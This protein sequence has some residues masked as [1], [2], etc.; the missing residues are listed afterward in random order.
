MALARSPCRFVSRIAAELG[1]DHEALQQWIKTAE[2]AERPEAVAASAKDAASGPLSAVRRRPGPARPPPCPAFRQR[3][4][5]PRARPLRPPGPAAP[6]RPGSAH[7]APARGR[8]AARARRQLAGHRSFI[9]GFT[10]GQR[11][12]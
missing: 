8:A 2:K 4:A 1:V 11:R 5:A 9:P 12:P 10:A 3:P 7:A 6:P